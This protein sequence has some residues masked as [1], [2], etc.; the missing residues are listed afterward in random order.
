M[1]LNATA[2]VQLEYQP[3]MNMWEV[4]VK[5]DG[6]YVDEMR[7][8]I[9][10]ELEYHVI[11]NE[12]T[13]RDDGGKLAIRL[14]SGTIQ[15]L[16]C[17]EFAGMRPLIELASIS[18]IGASSNKNIDFQSNFSASLGPDVPQRARIM[19]MANVQRVQLFGAVL[20]LPGTCITKTGRSAVSVRCRRWRC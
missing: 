5:V 7:H 20:S 15:K 11:T 8:V 19:Y 18:C 10:S 2:P 16:V 9:K 3:T 12:W 1:C 6:R 4:K 13:D 14:S 17:G